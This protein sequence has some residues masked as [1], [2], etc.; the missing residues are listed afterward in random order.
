MPT[1]EGTDV[2]ADAFAALSDPTR[3]AILQA[4]WDAE[5]HEASFSE[6]REAVGMRDSGQ[7]NYH[8]GKLTDQFVQQTEEGTY[9]LRL[10]GIHVVGSL[11][12]G[13]YTGDAAI[14]PMPSG[15]MCPDCGREATFEYDGDGFEIQCEECEPGWLLM[16][17]APR[18]V[19]EPYDPEE[20]PAVAGRYARELIREITN[21]FCPFCQ[22]PVSVEVSETE[23]SGEND[24]NSED[25]RSDRDGL[26]RAEFRCERCEEL[27]QTELG[28]P[29][30]EHPAVV[31][32][33]YDHEIDVREAPLFRLLASSTDDAWVTETDPFRAVVRYTVEDDA[34]ELTV[35][36]ELT[37]TDVWR[38][39]V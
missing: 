21:N 36:D 29:L 11:L 24:K 5:D 13:A 20:A 3:V 10:A 34:L 23:Q 26:P 6:L 4:L 1:D 19:F 17:P 7:F 32:F 33:F 16:M 12:A 14:G 39:D 38:S 30:H 31:S 37:V 9:E 25:E 2:S 15:E 35:D 8:L 18:G 22:G 27:F 28:V